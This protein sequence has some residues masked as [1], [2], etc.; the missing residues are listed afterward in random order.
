[1]CVD[2]KNNIIISLI[3]V[4]DQHCYLL[5]LLLIK[6]IL[7]KIFLNNIIQIFFGS[8]SSVLK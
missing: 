5:S 7:A 2:L 3:T 1:M 4:S 6:S 8:D